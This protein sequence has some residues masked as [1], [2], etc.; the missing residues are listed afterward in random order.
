MKCCGFIKHG[1]YFE[2][3]F[4]INTCT[5]LSHIGGGKLCLLSG[6]NEKNF[7]IDKLLENRLKVYNACRNGEEIP[8]CKGCMD[9]IEFE[10]LP[11]EQPKIKN[12]MFQ[13]WTKCNSNCI[14]CF[15][16]KD[17]KFYNSL[18][19]Y[20]V[21]YIIKKMIERNILD[22]NGMANFSGGEITC[23]KE[24]VK[25]VKLLDKLNYFI[26]ANSSGV[27][28]S[29]IMG[30]KLK[31][32]NG[33][34][35]ISVDAGSK[36][37]H[38]KIKRVK[39]WDRV[40]KNI[41]KYTKV[42]KYNDLVNVKYIIIPGINDNM[43]E[44]EKWLEKCKNANVHNVVLGIDSNYYEPNRDNISNHIL[45][46]FYETKKKADL[47]GNGEFNFYLGNRASIMLTTGKYKDDMWMD[48]KNDEIRVVNRYFNIV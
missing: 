37:V 48:Y 16:G 29:P 9:L 10:E 31:A 13:H 47:I 34:I 6:F 28:Y 7:D 39:T 21:Y 14:Y 5:Q 2:H 36:E 3:S 42:Q 22:K 38:E 45:N 11:Q 25:T 12:L 4:K 43:L 33:C 15:T 8:N 17:K 23:L 19:T 27:D 1:I 46:L 40:W 20:D 30:K 41:N 26:V 44:I 18:K 35:V 24:F 32:G